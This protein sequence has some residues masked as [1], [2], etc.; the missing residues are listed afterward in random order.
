MQRL[1]LVPPVIIAHRGYRKRYPENTL[2]AFAAAFDAG[3]CMVELDV[4]LTR[5]RRVVVLHDDTLDRTTDGC[6]QA[7]GFTLDE[8]K[9]LD[10]GN[11]FDPRFAGERLPTMEEVLGLCAGRGMVNI[12]IKAGA[13]EA[14]RLPDAIEEQVLTAVVERGMS[15]CVLI[16][17]F[18]TRFLSRIADRANAPAVGVLTEQ[19]IGSDPLS[20]CK[21]LRAFSWHPD[22]RSVTSARVRAMHAAGIMVFPYTVNQPEEYRVLLQMGVDGVFTDDPLLLQTAIG[23]VAGK[24]TSPP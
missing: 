12:E 24:E 3:A 15:D 10:A 22:F 14:G 7:R 8:L 20:L 21:R 16:S 2:A 1:S 13:F 19:R 23:R 6:G 18:E 5:D 4:T 9:Q 17:S 11:W